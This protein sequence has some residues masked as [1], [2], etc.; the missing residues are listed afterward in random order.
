MPP[1]L[2][3][4]SFHLW[5]MLGLGLLI[6][7]AIVLAR[8]SLRFSYSRQR[9]DPARYHLEEDVEEFG[10][11]VREGHGPLPIFFRLVVLGW[12][13]WATGYVIYRAVI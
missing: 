5:L 4:H 8:G 7:I 13:L 1:Y 10:G 6:A 2:Q 9:K 3:L 11:G 12:F